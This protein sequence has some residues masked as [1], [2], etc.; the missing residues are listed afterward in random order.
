MVWLEYWAAASCMV[1][2]KINLCVCVCTIR[3]YG[4]I[5][6]SHKKSKQELLDQINSSLPNS[7]F[8]KLRIRKSGKCAVDKC[9]YNLPQVQEQIPRNKTAIRRW[10]HAENSAG[11]R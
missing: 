3:L 10:F 6:L 11:G 9:A 5:F 1:G 7:H 8:P 2:E 4:K